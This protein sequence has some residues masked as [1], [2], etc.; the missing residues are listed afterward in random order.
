MMTRGHRLLLTAQLLA[1]AAALAS[2][3][4]PLRHAPPRCLTAITPP[5]PPPPASQ[6]PPPPP[7][8]LCAAGEG[9]APL[10]PWVLSANRALIGGMKGALDAVYGDGR[11]YAR[12]YVLETVARVPYFAYVACLHLQESLG[13]RAG[14]ERMRLHYA[15]ADNELHH[16]L[17]M[18]ALGGAAR[19]GDRIVAQHLA[20][21]YSRS[22][23]ITRDRTRSHRMVAQHL[24]VAYFWFVAGVYL[25]APRTA[26]HLS[27]EVERHA[28]R[29]YDAFLRAHEAELRLCT[30]V[31][32]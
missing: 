16:L 5:P 8:P 27:E 18:E 11:E 14:A 21:A 32:L 4:A 17:I 6:P 23:E 9:V 22:R 28:Y 26:Y 30:Y 12:F 24:A 25:L 19:Y 2:P 7:A 29:T 13:N 10:A 31:Y 20:V 15:E 3:R 1:A